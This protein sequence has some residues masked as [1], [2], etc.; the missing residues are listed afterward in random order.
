MQQKEWFETWF[1]S[2]Y[3]HK[4]YQHRN[5]DDAIMLIDNLFEYLKPETGSKILDLACGRGRHAAYIARKGFSTTGVDISENSIKTAIINYNIPNLEFYTH[6]MRDPV[7]INYF[8]Y[9]FNFF[10]SFGYFNRPADNKKV[11]KSV[12]L[13]LKPRGKFLIDFMNTTRVLDNLV[14]RE[15][16]DV[17][18]TEFYIRREFLDNKILKHIKFDAEGRVYSYTERVQALMP[19]HFHNLFNDTRFKIL[20]EFGNYKLEPFDTKKSERYMVLVEKA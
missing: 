12:N 18:G 10:T 8:D 13:S 4:L 19:Y 1:N 2:P 14:E 7:R 17:D 3:Y 5:E 15:M 9:V 16:V 11:L 6:D 20:A